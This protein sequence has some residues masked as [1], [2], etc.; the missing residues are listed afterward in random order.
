[1]HRYLMPR[2]RFE[3]EEI[4]QKLRAADVLLSPGKNAAEVRRQVSGGNCA[5]F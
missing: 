3:T 4:I 1:M 2:K 5:S